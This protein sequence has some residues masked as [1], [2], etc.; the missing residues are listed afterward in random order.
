MKYFVGSL[1]LTLS[2]TAQAHFWKCDFDEMEHYRI[3]CRT[4]TQCGKDSACF[5]DKVLSCYCL[6]YEGGRHMKSNDFDFNQVAIYGNFCGWRNAAPV[7]D[8][9]NKPQVLEIVKNLPAIDAL[10]EICKEHDIDYYLPNVDYCQADRKAMQSMN[11]LAKN[12]EIAAAVREQALAMSGALYFNRHTCHI[13][14][15][16]K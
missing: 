6:T 11:A 3:Q 12:L 4:S 16:L 10:D 7:T 13:L 8:W 1:L 2:L 14:K 9:A 15:F 5:D